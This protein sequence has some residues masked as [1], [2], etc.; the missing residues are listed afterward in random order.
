MRSQRSTAFGFAALPDQTELSAARGLAVR[1]V[2][3][4]SK[5]AGFK[6]VRPHSS[7]RRRKPG[8]VARARATG[9]S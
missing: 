3:L 4:P 1:L 6:T 2:T 7:Q 5:R 9:Y 8:P